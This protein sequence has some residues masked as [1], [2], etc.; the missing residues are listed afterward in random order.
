MANLLYGRAKQAFL[1]AE[2]NLGTGNTN[3]VAMKATLSDA[4]D[5]TVNS[6]HTTYATDVPN[7]AKVAVSAALGSITVTNGT[8]DAGDFT[9][10]GVSGDQSEQIILWA[11]SPTA[12]VAD[13]L[14]AFYDT[15]ITGM[16]VTPNSGDINVTVNAG[17]WFSL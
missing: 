14:V 17:G 13:P 2:L 12:P 9:W 7:S 10:T 6:T 11:D 5:Y 8:Y 3:N 16:P 15:G 1:A 4:A